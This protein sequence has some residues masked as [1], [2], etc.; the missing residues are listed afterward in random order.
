MIF[1][2]IIAYLY[3]SNLILLGKNW[4]KWS[5]SSFGP[6]IKFS[7]RIIWKTIKILSVKG[8]VTPCYSHYAWTFFKS[9]HR[10]KSAVIIFQ[11][12]QTGIFYLIL[13]KSYKQ[14]NKIIAFQ[15][16]GIILFCFSVYFTSNAFW[17]FYHVRVTIFCSIFYY[18]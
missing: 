11:M 5:K 18:L 14:K 2:K 17:V 8:I 13:L 4:K 3:K 7:H 6:R 10:F 1:V 15:E 16:F 12:P 9:Y